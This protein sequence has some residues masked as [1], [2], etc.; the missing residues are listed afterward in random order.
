MCA[1]CGAVG[2]DTKLVGNRVICKR[3]GAFFDKD[4]G[5]IIGLVFSEGEFFDYA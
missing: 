4:S 1:W 3:C 5:K 2:D